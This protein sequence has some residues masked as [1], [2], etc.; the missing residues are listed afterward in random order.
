MADTSS[1][2]RTEKPSAKKFKDAREKGQIARSKDLSMAIS[3]VAVITTLTSLGPSMCLQLATRIRSGLAHVGDHPLAVVT[4]PQLGMLVASD[5]RLMAMAVGPLLL[6]AGCAGLAGN[7]V[8][9]GFN[10]SVQALRLNWQRLSPSSG[11]ARLAPKQSGVDLVKA[12]IAVV[13]LS[14]LAWNTGRELVLDVPRLSWLAPVDAA[15]S[16]WSTVTRLLWHFGL[17]M[18][19]IALADYGVQHWR[20]WSS[21]KMTKQ[22]VRDESKSSEGSPEMKARVRKVQREMSRSRMLKA[23]KTATVVVTNPTHF[24]VAL[25]YRRDLM[26][27]P[28]VV[29]KGADFMAARI[30]AVAREHGVPTVENVSLAQ[31]LYKG[32]EVGDPI[33]GALFGAVAEV[34]AYLVRIKQL[35]L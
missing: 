4:S 15:V 14:A 12:V 30:K 25:E 1:E 16:G 24:A 10:V 11:L 17:A 6:V 22:E 33:P 9:S 35:M 20:L 5:G 34:L 29:A 23:V 8:Q 13:I 18:L 2:P 7:V 19:A 31:A 21:L 26:A 28:V 32:A 27:A 3:A